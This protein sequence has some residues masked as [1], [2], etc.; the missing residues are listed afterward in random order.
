MYGECAPLLRGDVPSPGG[1]WYPVTSTYVDDNGGPLPEK[2]MALCE[3]IE[4]FAIT[5]INNPAASAKAQSE[6]PV[7]WD[8]W[9]GYNDFFGVS[10]VDEFNHVPGGSN[11]LYM[12]GHAEFIRFGAKFPV[13][14]SPEGTYGSVLSTW[15]G[16]VSGLL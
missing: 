2:Y 10:M 1:T 13:A 16:H 14:N 9:A 7:M 12:D 4:R 5:D 15:M 11:V 6:I 8:T 3:G